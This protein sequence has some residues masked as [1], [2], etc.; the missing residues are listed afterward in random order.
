MSDQ[1]IR[2]LER[3]VQSNPEDI[4]AAFQLMNSYKRVK[5]YLAIANLLHSSDLYEFYRLLSNLSEEEISEA[6]NAIIYPLV[7]EVSNSGD[8]DGSYEVDT[9]GLLKILYRFSRSNIKIKSDSL[10]MTKLNE[11]MKTIRDDTGLYD[12][13]GWVEIEHYYERVDRIERNIDNLILINDK[14]KRFKND[15][16]M[17]ETRLDRLFP[18]YNRMARI[19][20][21]LL[22]DT[23][24]YDTGDLLR[25]D[26]LSIVK[27]VGSKSLIDELLENIRLIYGLDTPIVK[28]PD[29]STKMSLEDLDL[30]VRVRASFGYENVDINRL[31]R[32]TPSELLN[33]RHFGRTSLKHLLSQLSKHGLYIR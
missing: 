10:I 33:L 20:I 2:Q 9:G 4:G 17:G 28:L 16:I 25:F 21:R 15:I 11:L 22:Q 7:V 12:N 32:S 3:Y 6:A 14:Y 13:G 19:T 23:G 8:E 27:R 26:Y 29:L 1:R 31:L 30:N 24:I 5:N 18:D